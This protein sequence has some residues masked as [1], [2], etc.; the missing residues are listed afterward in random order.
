MAGGKVIHTLDAR[1]NILLEVMRDHFGLSPAHM[2]REI[3]AMRENVEL[4]LRAKAIDYT[5]LKSALVPDRKRKEAAFI[6]DTQAISSNW[7]GL[8]VFEQLLPLLDKTSNHSILVGDYIARTGQEA[9]L[10]KA[11]N[12]A[13][14][15]VR[16]VT[17]WHPSQLYVVYL[18]NLTEKMLGSLQ[19]GLANY[20]GYIGFADT[21]YASPFKAMLSTMLVN[22]GIKHGEVILQGHE[23]DRDDTDNVNM[24]GYPFS[25]YGYVCKSISSDLMGVFLSYKIERPIY[26]GFEVDTEFSLNAISRNPLL[27]KDFDVEVADAKLH[28]IVSKKTA[29]AARAG[30]IETSAKQ[31]SEIIKEKIESNYIYS[32][33]LDAAHN[34]AKFNV[35]L[36][37]SSNRETPRS[38]HLASLEYKPT[39]KRLRL[40]TLF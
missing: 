17:I 23:D 22:L 11:M 21:T 7:Y 35:M 34:V 8:D 28:Y 18:N 37:F 1:G 38:R 15:F 27:L 31:L 12:G 3:N 10:L 25:Q 33:T 24:C 26:P 13:S 40:I 9:T 20:P 5:K 36:E 19:A 4:K 32:M 6:F 14:T 30:I 16:D 2:F 29:S 39:E